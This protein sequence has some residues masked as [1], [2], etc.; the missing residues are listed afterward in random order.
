MVRLIRSLA[1]AVAATLLWSGAAMAQACGTVTTCPTASMPLSGSELL[2][3]V[4]GGVS[5]KI[6]T[7]SIFGASQP[8]N[9]I[10]LSSLV[11]QPASTILANPA[12]STGPVGAY[13]IGSTLVFDGSPKVLDLASGAA[14]ANLGYTT[15]LV[16][17][18][19][20]T[21][22]GAW[23]NQTIAA[24]GSGSGWH[25]NRAGGI[26]CRTT[27]G[28]G[29]AQA[30]ESPQNSRRADTA[31]RDRGTSDLQFDVV[32]LAGALDGFG[33]IGLDGGGA[34]LCL[35][36]LFGGGRGSHAG[37]VLGAEFGVV[38]G[39][40][41]EIG[42]DGQRHGKRAEGVLVQQHREEEG[43]HQAAGGGLDAASISLCLAI[44]S[45][46]RAPD[47]VPPCQYLSTAAKPFVRAPSMTSATSRAPSGIALVRI[48]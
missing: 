38:L 15:G 14:A 5:K 7:G 35:A 23:P 41:H 17:G 40:P 33:G 29:V 9:S 47:A 39:Q 30:V 22:T 46:F 16:A 28:S 19:N 6:T 43:R 18:T 20:I 24:G 25:D 36:D 1:V 32:H 3:L 4:Q 13:G 8:A 37:G 10:A 21:L 42:T 31:D 34:F 45:S 27:T 44:V 12:G 48:E 26:T 11:N 2:Y